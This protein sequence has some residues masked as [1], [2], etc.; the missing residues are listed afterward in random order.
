MSPE[1]FA[2]AIAEA[3]KSEDGTIDGI[4]NTLST[5]D[6]ESEFGK[7]RMSSDIDGIQECRE[8]RMTASYSDDDCVLMHYKVCMLLLYL[9]LLMNNMQKGGLYKGRMAS[10]ASANQSRELSF[11]LGHI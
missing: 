2:D 6:Y 10:S 1:E 5:P 8:I 3:C 4:Q 7:K 11:C 9:L